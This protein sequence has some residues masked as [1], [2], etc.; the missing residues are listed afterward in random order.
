MIYRSALALFGL[1]CMVTM[2]AAANEKAEPD[3]TRSQYWEPIRKLMFGDRE[4][5]DGKDVIRVYLA[6]RADD[7]STVPVAVK[8]QIDQTPERYIKTVY[9][10]VERNPSPAAGVFHFTPDSGRAQVETRLRFEDYSHVRAIAET[11]DGQLWMDS[12]WVKAAGGCSAPGGRFRVPAALLGKMKFR[13][14]D[15]VTYNVPNLVQV[16]IRHPNESALAADFD[17]SQVPQFVRS[18]N[19]TYSGMP[20]MSAEVDFSLSDNPTF[21]FWFVPRE[22]GELRVEVED[23]HDNR[24]VE[25]LPVYEGAALPGG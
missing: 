10:V 5:H 25:T 2:P 22:R 6:L 19:V 13:F 8:A 9:L 23:T 17:A 16:N 7:A 18:I 14:D 12:R 20:V 21:R 3:P 1:L 15:Q 4:I 11:N 24:F